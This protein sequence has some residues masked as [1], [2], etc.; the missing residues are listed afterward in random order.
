MHRL[1][2]I[3]WGVK[4]AALSHSRATESEPLDNDYLFDLQI[5]LKMFNIQYFENQNDICC[6]KAKDE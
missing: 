5:N 3:I 1:P 2:R 6:I 4:N